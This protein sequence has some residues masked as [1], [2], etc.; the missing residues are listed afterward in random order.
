MPTPPQLT[1]EQKLEARE[2]YATGEYA[3]STLALRFGCSEQVMY[4]AL[5]G[6]HR[7]RPGG[8]TNPWYRRQQQNGQA[9]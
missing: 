2:L 7:R 1:E 6:M 3:A 4:R 9:D 5:K 8:L